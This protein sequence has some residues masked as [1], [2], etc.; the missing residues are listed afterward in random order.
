MLRLQRLWQ[1][2][3][4]VQ[5]GSRKQGYFTPIRNVYNLHHQDVTLIIRNYF[6]VWQHF[7]FILIVSG[8][9]RV[10]GLLLHHPKCSCT[11]SIVY[12]DKIQDPLP[13]P[14]LAVL[15]KFDWYCVFVRLVCKTEPLDNDPEPTT[16]RN[17]GVHVTLVSRT[18][19]YFKRQRGTNEFPPTG[20]IIV[21]GY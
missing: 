12:R 11:H 9:H 21:L 19:T 18:K 4:V 3:E 20:L 1:L 6:A 14:L 2:S 8:L 16:M 5:N 7:F 17:T 13:L 15:F 10:S